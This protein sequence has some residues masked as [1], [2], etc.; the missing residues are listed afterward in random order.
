MIKI[1]TAW[2]IELIEVNGTEPLYWASSKR[3]LLGWSKN[4]MDA[5]KFSTEKQA[6]KF[7]E[8]LLE[9]VRV[10]QHEWTIWVDYNEYK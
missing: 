5:T 3:V 7:S 6:L 4:H 9:D 2:L 1:E 10:C 8:L